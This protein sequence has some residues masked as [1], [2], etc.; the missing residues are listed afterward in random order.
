MSHVVICAPP[1][2]SLV[3][4]LNVWSS[5]FSQWTNFMTMILMWAETDVRS[6]KMR[7]HRWSW[8]IWLNTWAIQWWSYWW[9]AATVGAVK[10]ASYCMVFMKKHCNYYSRYLLVCIYSTWNLEILLEI[11]KSHLKSWNSWNPEILREIYKSIK[12]LQLN[13]M[14]LRLISP[15]A[16]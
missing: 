4:P 2:I 11:L 1:P 7:L 5:L 13:S 8:I 12:P 15:A 6:A 14:F 9:R 3:L 10:M 16:W